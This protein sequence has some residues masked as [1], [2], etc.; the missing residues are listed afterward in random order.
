[1]IFRHTPMR[2]GWGRSMM[3]TPASG[4]ARPTSLPPD[5]S[6]LARATNWA[7]WSAVEAE[8]KGQMCLLP[9]FW[10]CAE[11]TRLQATLSTALGFKSSLATA[12]ASPPP[13][14][15]N[16]I[17]RAGQLDVHHPHPAHLRARSSSRHQDCLT[18]SSTFIATTILSPLLAEQDAARR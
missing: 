1:M 5:P 4:A 17:Q 14:R 8:K 2:S 13:H 16:P 11:A 18:L 7:T 6:S 12:L 15:H 3:L 9:C 10:C